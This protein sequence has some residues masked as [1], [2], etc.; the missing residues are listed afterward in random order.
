MKEEE[1]S[2]KTIEDEMETE[3]LILRKLSASDIQNIYQVVK[4]DIVG[5]VQ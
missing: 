1:L 3:R 2:K 5:V 4:Q